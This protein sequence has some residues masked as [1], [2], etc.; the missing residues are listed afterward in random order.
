[1]NSLA[2]GRWTKRLT[3]VVYFTKECPR[4]TAAF[5]I[6]GV[7][8]APSLDSIAL[9]RGYS[10]TIRIAQLT[11]FS[12]CTH[13]YWAYEYGVELRLIR[14]GKQT[15]IGLIHS[16]TVSCGDERMIEHRI[17]DILQLNL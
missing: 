11:G 7:Q 9:F 17:S 1:M 12:C 4:I 15:Q 10:A 13:A 16:L 5:G 14:P 3:Y 2:R 6:S 8:I